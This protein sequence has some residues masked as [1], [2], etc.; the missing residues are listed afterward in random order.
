MAPEFRVFHLYLSPTGPTPGAGTLTLC[1]KK[2]TRS[3]TRSAATALSLALS[4]PNGGKSR[5][6]NSGNGARRR[7]AGGR[8]SVL[9]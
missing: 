4:L 5:V 3:I 9:M 7:T 8:L 1:Q 6:I 2:R